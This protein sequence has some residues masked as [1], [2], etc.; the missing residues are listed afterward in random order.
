MKDFFK[1]QLAEDKK[2]IDHLLS[3]IKKCEELLKKNN[4]SFEKRTYIRTLFSFIEAMGS[5]LRR[6]ALY[7]IELDLQ[8]KATNAL[9][10]K[11]ENKTHMKNGLNQ[12]NLCMNGL[13]FV[14]MVL[15]QAQLES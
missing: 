11:D 9:K 12:E 2:L 4:T 5:V 6:H 13:F 1:N 10:V 8:C 14:K 7:S 15:S 3:D